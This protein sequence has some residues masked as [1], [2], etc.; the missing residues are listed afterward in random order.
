MDL[1]PPCAGF[2]LRF[3]LVADVA[4]GHHPKRNDLYQE[5]SMAI[6]HQRL[7]RIVLAARQAAEAR[8]KG[9]RERALCAGVYAG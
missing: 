9:Y 4:A 6:D 1:S 2:F 5:L 3:L 8:E 7:D